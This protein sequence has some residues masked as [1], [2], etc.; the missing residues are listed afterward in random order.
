MTPSE[1]AS[2]S[3]IVS[4]G[5]SVA[6]F[7]TSSSRDRAAML[8]ALPVESRTQE[9][10]AEFGGGIP[11][12]QVMLASGVALVERRLAQLEAQIRTVKHHK[13]ESFELSGD[14]YHDNPGFRTLQ[15]EEE[16]LLGEKSRLLTLLREG[17]VIEPGL[18]PVFATVGTVVHLE[19]P[20]GKTV[21]YRIVGMEGASDEVEDEVVTVTYE[22]PIAKTLLGKKVGEE[23]ELGFGGRSEPMVVAA[24]E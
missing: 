13:N 6:V 17:V 14:G 21:D 7:D 1:R 3:T 24:I 18:P 10:Q 9:V 8:R 11:G 20:D 2:T 19:G 16:A 4:T 15:N 23:V 12:Y 5:G 22:A